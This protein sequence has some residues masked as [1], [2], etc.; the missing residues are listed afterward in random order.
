MSSIKDIVNFDSLKKQIEEIDT[1]LILLVVDSNVY[2]IYRTK[3]DFLKWKNKKVFLWKSLD[4]ESTKTYDELKHCLEF[5]LSKNIHRNAHLVAIGGGACSDFGGMVA[6]L[7]LRGIKW[8]VVPTTMLSMIDAAIGGKVAINSEYGKNLVGAFNLPENIY[9][10]NDFLKTLD[11]SNVY[12]GNGELFKYCFLNK[13]I[14]QAVVADREISEV[15]SMCAAY[16][17]SIVEQDFKESG[18][19]KYLNLGH[20]FG[21]AIEKIYK[22]PHG[23]A[24]AW[25]MVIIFKLYDLEH[26]LVEMKTLLDHIEIDMKESVW[27]NKNFPVDEIMTYIMK[28]KKVASNTEIDIVLSPNIGEVEIRRVSFNELNERLLR[29]EDELRR[30]IF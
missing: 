18:M 16:K 9:I 4:G 15:I 30:F 3:F 12:C 17:Q 21:H 5:F 6:S 7:I 23:V 1:D 22:L 10:V 13:E 2:N 25:G 8:S 24:V 29:K 27:F 26:S 11:K 14:Y 19:R 20:T 28:D